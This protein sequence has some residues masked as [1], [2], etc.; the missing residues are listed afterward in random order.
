MLATT[1][2]AMGANV[3]P[4]TKAAKVPTAKNMKLD[5][6][7]QQCIRNRLQQKGTH[8]ACFTLNYS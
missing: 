8:Y 1:I 5:H 6:L 7:L 3:Q 4:N 2:L